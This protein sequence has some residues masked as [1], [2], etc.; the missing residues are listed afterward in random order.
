VFLRLAAGIGAAHR[1]GGADR[2]LR[3][4]RAPRGR[5]ASAGRCGCRRAAARWWRDP[6]RTVRV[7]APV[8]R[9]AEG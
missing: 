4:A 7:G 6:V 8:W 5:G 9:A 2:P 3:L 1:T